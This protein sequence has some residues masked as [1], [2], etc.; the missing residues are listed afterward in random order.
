L[1][2]LAGASHTIGN[3]NATAAPDASWIF[4]DLTWICWETKSEAKPDGE[5]GT[6]VVTQAGGH[7]RWTADA[8]DAAVPSDSSVFVVSPQ[9]TVH[10]A[11]HAVAEDHVY[12][13]GPEKVVDLFERLTRAWRKLRTRDPDTVELGVALALLHEERALPSQWLTDLRQDPLA[14]SDD[15]P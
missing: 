13:T 11:A 12:L 9:Q 2:T 7:L 1:G 6:N 15:A 3:N 14:R 5:L 10:P 4:G 8:R